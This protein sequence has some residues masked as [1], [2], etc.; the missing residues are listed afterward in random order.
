M[1]VLS[2][3]LVLI[4][5]GTI[6]APVGAV[7][8][9]YSDNLAGLVITPQIKDLMNGNGILA[10]GYAVYDNNNQNDNSVGGGLVMPTFVSSSVNSVDRTFQVVVNVT[11]PLNEDLT[12]NSIS[13]DVECS[14]DHYKLGLISLASPVTISSGQSSLLTV[15][16]SWTQSA[17][18]HIQS[19]HPDQTAISVDLINTSID[20][21]GIVAQ[22]S[23]P[24]TIP[25]GIPIT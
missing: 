19:S 17:E 23:T 10:N 13:A 14:Q 8:V 25:D 4:S 11:D 1:Q 20:L 24:V 15:S 6:V 16:G 7:V 22:Y 5:I 18:D 12:I 2:V 9:M 3:I 21:N